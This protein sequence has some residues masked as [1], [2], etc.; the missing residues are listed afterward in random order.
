[1]PCTCKKDTNVGGKCFKLGE[2]GVVSSDGGK[3]GTFAWQRTFPERGKLY[4]LTQ[5]RYQLHVIATHG[6]LLLA[7]SPQPKLVWDAGG[8]HFGSAF[9]E[10]EETRAARITQRLLKRLLLLVWQYFNA[11]LFRVRT[12]LQLR[13]DACAAHL[14]AMRLPVQTATH[15]RAQAH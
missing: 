15:C 11:L 1:M 8:W 14:P 6:R 7:S 13:L 9:A 4:R 2:Q 3:E 10:C 5:A 12:K